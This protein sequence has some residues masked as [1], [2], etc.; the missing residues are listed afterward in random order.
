[1]DAVRAMGLTEES[2]RRFSLGLREP[3]LSRS[4]GEIT[5]KALTFPVALP[6]GGGTH[7][8]ACLNLE[9][10]TRHP[11][12]PVGWGAGPPRTY[13]SGPL[14]ANVTILVVPEVLDMW[15]LSQTFG[16]SRSN[17]VFACRSHGDGYPAEW[18]RASFWAPFSKVVLGFRENGLEGPSLHAFAAADDVPFSRTE[19]PGGGTWTDL[20]LGGASL[21]ELERLVLEAAPWTP[22][23]PVILADHAP[24]SGDFGVEPVSVEGAVVGGR[25][26]WPVTVE[27]R[28]F[29]DTRSRGA[30]LVQRYVVQVLRSDG[31][32]L[33]AHALPAP[34]GTPRS[35]RVLALSDG[36]R[37]SAMPAMTR[38][39]TWRWASIAA[40]M[41][42]RADGADPCSRALARIRADVEERL[43]A[44]VW[45]QSDDAYCLLSLFVIATY[46]HRIFDAL[47]ILLING[48]RSSGKSELGQALAAL[49][50]NSVVAGRVTAA[51]LVRLLAETRGLVVLDD[52]ERIGSG[53]GT[54]DVSQLLK[55]SYKQATAKRITPGRDGRVEV[56]DFFSPKVVTNICGADPVLLS[57]MITVATSPLPAAVP[58]P[59]REIGDV[60]ALRDELHAWAMASA[61]SV[62]AAYRSRSAESRGRADEI[63]SALWTISDLVGEQPVAQRLKSFLST[64]TVEPQV[65]ID[66]ALRRV[67]RRLIAEGCAEVAMPRIQLELALEGIANAPSEE[68][69]GRLLIT[70]GARSHNDQVK[71]RRLHGKLVRIY[72]IPRPT[73]I[74]VDPAMAGPEPLAFCSARCAECRYEPV[75]QQTLRGLRDRCETI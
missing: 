29:D 11:L 63:A 57:R 1:M 37:I 45:L 49:S 48:P 70:L 6:D 42:A 39:G 65:R 3:Y 74:G 62:C 58:A 15:L 51:G 27:R 59:S 31:R 41:Q 38:F 21:S 60:A 2:I 23:H 19:P 20:V 75:C 34:V 55:V 36:V 25:M 30:E 67:M 73:S 26:Y 46:V 68:S 43:R 18:G 9:G 66:E 44:S 56:L 71:R 13:F 12:D 8:W 10:V 52:L 40:F 64:T 7:R 24:I 53:V 61:T 32:L 33:D 50:A 4:T 72:R 5:E 17:I 54:D 22:A 69:I 28:H 35:A 14:T 47:P 16:R